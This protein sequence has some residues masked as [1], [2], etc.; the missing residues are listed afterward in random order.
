M[1][2]LQQFGDFFSITKKSVFKFKHVKE[3]VQ[4][5][6]L[7][8]MLSGGVNMYYYTRQIFV[9]KMTLCCAITIAFPIIFHNVQHIGYRD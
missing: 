9:I 3:M 7:L 6:G 8:S 1:I 4:I 2:F 5:E